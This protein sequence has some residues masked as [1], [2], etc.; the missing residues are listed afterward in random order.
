MRQNRNA[1][2]YGQIFIYALTLVL[3]SVILVYGYISI[4]N[5][6]QKT[7]DIVAIKFQRDFKSAIDSITSDYGSVSRKEFQL[8]GEITRVCF[9]ESFETFN[10]N[11]PMSNMPPLDNIVK[12]SIRDSD[13]NVFLLENSLKSSF[14]AGSISVAD[15]VLCINPAGSR[16]VLR[17]EGKGDHVALSEWE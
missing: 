8:S 9:V 17:L 16:I 10:R 2:L 14:S 6:T 7:E 3:V 11:N 4:R 12:N 1:Q 15:D 5:F 13:K